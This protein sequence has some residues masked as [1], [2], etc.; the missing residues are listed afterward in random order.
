MERTLNKELLISVVVPMYNCDKTIDR[1]INSVINQTY[2]NWE[3]VLI[4]DGSLDKTYSKCNSWQ[5][6][7][8]RIK[9]IKKNNKGPSSAR[10]YGIKNSSGEYLVFL[11]SDDY[12]DSD[13]LESLYKILKKDEP[14]TIFCGYKAKYEN[15]DSAETVIPEYDKSV[16]QQNEIKDIISRFIGYSMDDFYSK[17]NGKYNKNREFAA[18]WRF[19]YSTKVIKEYE[20]RFDESVSFGE[21]IIFNSLYLAFCKKI[22]ISNITSYNY[23][24]SEN[25]LVQHFLEEDGVELC[26]HKIDLLKARDMITNEIY[27]KQKIDISSTWM[28]S[29]LFSAMH[30]GITLAQTKSQ[31]FVKK[32]SL[33]KEYTKSTV[34]RKACKILKIKKLKFKYK[35]CFM[36]LKLHAYFMQYIMLKIANM[37]GI[38]P[39]VED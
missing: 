15:G 24:Y 29:V 21:D 8:S 17:L 19:C 6:K 39:G 11:D 31:K 28:G 3:L 37:I 9:L 32:Y 7:N 14:D 18:V 13:Y 34:C 2:L 35:I 12:L 25:G 26:K 20:I 23:Q 5:Q 10:N 30:I 38:S 33:F 27:Q 22:V 16:F 36:P 4:D 1:C